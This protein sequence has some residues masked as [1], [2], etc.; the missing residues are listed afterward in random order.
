MIDR[1]N[2]LPVTL[3]TGFLGAGKTT[4]LNRLLRDP[5]AERI[6]VIMNEFGS[7]GLDHDLIEETTEEITLMQSGC[8]CCTFRGDI[9]KTLGSL[10]S[11][12][13]TGELSFDRVVIETT[14]IA[15]PGPILHTLVTDDLVAST[16]VMDGVVTVVDAAVGPATL[17]THS[18]AVNQIAMADLLV[19]TKQDLVTPEDFSAFLARIDA[20]NGRARRVYA[21]HGSIVDGTIFG[22]S[23]LREGATI[24]ETKRWLGLRNGEIGSVKDSGYDRSGS[25][26][27]AQST[28]LEI[29]A[30]TRH[31]HGISSASIELDDP[32][33]ASVFDF[34]LDTLMAFKGSDILRL[35]G[36]IHIEGTDQ[37]MVFHG[38]QH[39]LETPVPLSSELETTGTSRIVV[40]ARNVEKSDL[41]ASLNMLRMR[42]TDIDGFLGDLMAHQSKIAV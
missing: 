17:D 7:M 38:V 5:K 21:D 2:R 4:L 30:Q 36:I 18:E 22:M 6:A 27:G 24:D 11:R 42:L 31:D 35:K 3:L 1:E 41:E 12:R 34:W 32:I 9:S 13:Q 39:I 19:V 40:I 20:I 10:K 8:L 28:H 26:V 14:G 33:P 37:P 25:A 16:Y 29:T 23:A 15:E